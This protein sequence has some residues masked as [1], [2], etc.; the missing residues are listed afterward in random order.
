MAMS[1]A[2]SK[3]Q[4]TLGISD[5]QLGSQQGILQSPRS[6]MIITT[7]NKSLTIGTLTSRLSESGDK[8]KNT[9]LLTLDI[10]GNSPA[11]P[12]YP[13]INFVIYGR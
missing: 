5:T 9:S 13:L 2:M 4:I 1:L 6:N 3:L 12:N 8:H 11:L 10:D 7:S